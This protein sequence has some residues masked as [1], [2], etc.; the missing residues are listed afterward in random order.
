[1]KFWLKIEFLGGNK[2]FDRKLKFWLKIEFLGENKTFDRQLKLKYNNQKKLRRI[3]YLPG[4]TSKID[5]RIFRQKLTIEF[6]VKNW[7]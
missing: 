3:N 2:T 6:S 7:Q 4:I 1:M 5:N